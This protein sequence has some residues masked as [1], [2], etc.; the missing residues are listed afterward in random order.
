MFLAIDIGGTK[1]LVSTFDGE[2]MVIAELKFSTPSSYQEL[3]SSLA[4]KAKEI[5]RNNDKIEIVGCAVPVPIDYKTGIPKL[6]HKFGWDEV[7]IRTDLQGIFNCQVV[8][9]NDANLAALSEANL[10]AGLD[11]ETVL[12]ITISTGIGTGIIHQGRIEPFLASAEGGFMYLCNDGKQ[13]I[14]ENFAS[15]R[16]FTEHYDKMGSEVDDPAIWKKYAS[17]LAAGFLNLIIIVEPDVVVVGGGMGANFSKYEHF[18]LDEIKSLHGRL[19]TTN[20][21]AIVEAKLPENAVIH[22][23]YLLAKSSLLSP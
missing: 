12:Y 7:D 22:G 3:L 10:G 15:G 9:E 23:A 18:L 11:Y 20:L 8:I 2:G 19:H 17:T 16:A 6:G 5:N 1:T 4:A 14:W 13:D 21:P